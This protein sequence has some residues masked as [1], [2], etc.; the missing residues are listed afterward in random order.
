MS[1]PI[2]KNMKTENSMMV[3]MVMENVGEITSKDKILSKLQFASLS[4]VD[5]ARRISKEIDSFM[6]SVTT[7]SGVES[8]ISD[9]P[10]LTQVWFGDFYDNIDGGDAIKQ[11]NIDLIE[12]M[13]SINHDAII[14]RVIDDLIS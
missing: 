12:T 2:M 10:F 8:K 11:L 6:E 3:D 4:L 13:N 7:N 9:C 5:D 14:N 1:I